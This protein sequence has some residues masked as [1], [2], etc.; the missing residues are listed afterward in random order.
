M[1]RRMA[2]MKTRI[3]FVQFLAVSTLCLLIAGG[4]TSAEIIPA[5]NLRSLVESA[6]LIVLGRVSAPTDLGQASTDGSGD[7]DVRLMTGRIA[8]RQ[9]LK[10][11]KQD[12][13][14]FWS[15]V[16][17]GAVRVGDIAPDVDGVFMLKR[18]ATNLEFVSPFY[19]VLRTV[20]GPRIEA[21]EPLDAVVEAMSMV[22]QVPM[23]S[24]AMKRRTV[25][26]LGRLPLPAAVPALRMAARDSNRDVH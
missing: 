14:E 10:G 3:P 21:A 23:T 12:S 7:Q 22:F 19:P 26:D 15:P 11:Q 1:L 8:V 4:R 5:L 2:T 20:V 18:R 25:Y 24:A 16:W 9:V 17:R 6:D 13:V